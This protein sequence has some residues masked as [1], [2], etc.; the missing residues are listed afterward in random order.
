[1]PEKIKNTFLVIVC[2]ILNLAKIKCDL[3][4]RGTLYHLDTALLWKDDTLNMSPST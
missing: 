2:F 3:Y 1:M 4:S